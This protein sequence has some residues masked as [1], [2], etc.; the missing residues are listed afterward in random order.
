MNAIKIVF[1]LLNEYSGALTFIVTTVYVIATVKILKANDESAKATREQVVESRRQF[2][3]NQRL[4]IMPSFQINVSKTNGGLSL[5]NMDLLILSKVYERESLFS[6]VNLRMT[7]KNVG[8]GPAK[9]MCYQ[10]FD[11]DEI[12]DRGSFPIHSLCTQEEHKILIDV[13]LPDAEQTTN[14]QIRYQPKII[15]LFKD[16]LGNEYSQEIFLHF[17]FKHEELYSDNTSF[18]FDKYDI[19]PAKCV[20]SMK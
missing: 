10:W 1:D 15:L 11:T 19:K 2:S 3:E 5:P 16:L 17:I 14:E 8:L 7:I 6:V 12:F 4:Q 18:F 9:D 13:S 20:H